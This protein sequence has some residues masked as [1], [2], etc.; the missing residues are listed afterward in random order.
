MGDRGRKAEREGD[1]DGGIWTAGQCIGL[2]KD[3]PST[4]AFV[5]RFIAEAVK[6]LRDVAAITSK[7]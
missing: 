4:S 3:I 5:E 7:L 1:A 2:I 6:S